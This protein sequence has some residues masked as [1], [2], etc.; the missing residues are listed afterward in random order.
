M[1]PSRPPALPAAIALIAL[2]SPTAVLA[3]TVPFTSER[4]EIDAAE[5]RV[6]TRMGRES[7]YLKGG[8]ATL[9]DVDF[10]NGTIE[11]DISATGER[12]FAGGV[13]RMQD[14]TNYEEFYIRPHQSGMPDAN[15]YTPV[16][17]GLAGWQLYH[18][19]GYGTPATYDFNGWIHVKI[20][21]AGRRGEVYIDSE[22]PVLA[23]REMKHGVQPGRIGVVAANFAPAWFS[24]FTYTPAANPPLKSPAGTPEAPPPGTV[25]RWKVS[26]AFSEQDLEGKPVLLDNDRK[27]LTWTVA[28]TESTGTL[29]I[30]RLRRIGEKR[31][32][33]L[34]GITIHSERDQVKRFSFGYSDRVR[35]YFNG[36]L[37]YG[38]TNL[39]RSR[40]YRYLGTI[41][42]FD[43]A[44][45]PLREGENELWL[46]VS[47]SFGGWGVRGRFEDLEGVVLTP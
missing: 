8:L 38:G 44:Y 14:R 28:E 37:I 15:Q 42:L 3:E 5:S 7:L 31:N 25:L 40:D 43:D 34:V 32:T 20:V 33:A 23:I 39:Y 10:L 35:L 24:G 46:A 16:F 1:R 18:G 41:G 19:E 6:V 30:A 21:V 2:L 27:G 17:N 29:N 12:G 22:E 26:N 11:F 47:E 36:R 4:W 9:R 13:W 45:L